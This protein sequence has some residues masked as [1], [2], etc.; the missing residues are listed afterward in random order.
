MALD[1]CLQ[2]WPSP[3]PSPHP[4]PP[5]PAFA[6]QRALP[7]TCGIWS[8]TGVGHGGNRAGHLS[9]VGQT[10]PQALIVSA[11]HSR[12]SAVVVRASAESRRAV[13]AAAGD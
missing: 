12:R 11:M 7:G 10:C 8:G 4:P 9:R 1:R 5:C 13:R 3:V 6:S 2:P